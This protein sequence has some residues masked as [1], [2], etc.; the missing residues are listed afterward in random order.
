MGLIQRTFTHVEP[1]L[2]CAVGGDPQYGGVYFPDIQGNVF[3]SWLPQVLY[4]VSARVGHQTMYVPGA[5]GQFSIGIDYGRKWMKEI[6][7]NGGWE[8]GDFSHYT[9]LASVFSGPGE[10]QERRQ[11]HNPSVKFD[12][13]VDGFYVQR[14]ACIGGQPDQ[15]FW[16]IG[17]E[18]EE[19]NAPANPE[20]II[21]FLDHLNGVS[22]GWAGYVNRNVIP[23]AKLRGPFGSVG[24]KVEVCLESSDEPLVISEAWIAPK[25]LTGNPWDFAGTPTR[26]TK[27]GAHSFTIPANRRA[28]LDVVNYAGNGNGA[29]VSF[30]LASSKTQVLTTAASVCN[31]WKAS[32][33]EA[34][35]IAPSGFT[36][37]SGNVA[38]PWVAT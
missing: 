9:P 6:L 31:Y 25:A 32:T 10:P 20:T 4:I 27:G 22:N 21:R 1:T 30:A 28:A 8:D 12:R 33:T 16:E 3:P 19:L 24:N 11:L 7:K 14:M 38:M 5:G 13:A 18:I 36:T 15:M 26:L 34:A 17:Y 2:T 23:E 35:T 29:V 37:G